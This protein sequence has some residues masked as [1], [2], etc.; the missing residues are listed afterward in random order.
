MMTSMTP[1]RDVLVKALPTQ[2]QRALQW[3]IDNAG[4][5]QPWPGM[6]DDNTLLATK[7]KGIYKPKWSRY[8]LSV[9]EVLGDPYPDREPVERDNG[10][11]SYRYFQENRDPDALMKEYTNRGLLA[12][13][14][15]RVPIGVMRQTRGKP[16]VRYRVLGV[17]L[18]AGWRDGYFEL[19]GFSPDGR[20]DA[21][22]P[23]TGDG[24][25]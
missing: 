2:H 6:L 4:T 15:D 16:N 18:V 1:M 20:C 8:A 23:G 11:W 22:S 12:C 19:E 9:R 5:I 24:G 17:A 10:T 25:V 7:A 21:A 3:F 13:R 14:D